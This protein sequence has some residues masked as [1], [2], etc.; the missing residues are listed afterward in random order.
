MNHS[1][2]PAMNWALVTEVAYPK[3]FDALETISHDSGKRACWMAYSV[4]MA[5]A[6]QLAVYEQQLAAVSAADR[7]TFCIGEESEAAA[8]RDR[9]RLQCLHTFLGEFFE[10]DWP[11]A[12]R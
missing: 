7:Q 4:P 6:N 5:Y 3:L 8:I 9:Y 2:K 11:K 10:S 1:A 12:P